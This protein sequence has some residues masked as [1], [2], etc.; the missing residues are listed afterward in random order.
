MYI[1]LI[2]GDKIMDVLKDRKFLNERVSLL[3]EEWGM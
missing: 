3:L 2:E 1:K